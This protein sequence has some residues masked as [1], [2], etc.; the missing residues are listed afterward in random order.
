MS[1]PP[2][3]EET[4][5]LR[6]GARVVVRPIR[7]ADKTLLA[8]GFERLSDQSVYRRFLSLMPEL[9]PMDLVYLT[10]VDHRDHEALLAIDAQTGEGVGVARYVR[11]REQ[12][13]A[14]EFAVTVVDDWH[15][16][17]VGTELLR[18]LAQRACAED[19]KRFSALIQ[20][21]NRAMFG[22]LQKL[23]GFRTTRTERGV[24]AV[25]GDLA[26]CA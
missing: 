26:L 1:L 14:A 13:D 23:G 21:D 4:A 3:F 6:D 15:R 19:V 12:P 9:R 11:L 17:G 18:R 20:A 5:V 7:P 24:S 16:R 2:A 22:L 8:E 25:E 10:E